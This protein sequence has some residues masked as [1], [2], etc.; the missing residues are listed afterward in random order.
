MGRD[1]ARARFPEWA[2][3]TP[4][5]AEAWCRV[6]SECCTAEEF[7]LDLTSTPG[8]PWNRSAR[9]VFIDDFLAVGVYGCRNR[10]KIGTAFDRHFRTLKKQYTRLE[11][12][13]EAEAEGT[14]VDRSME[15]QEHAREQR[16]YNRRL[17]VALYYPETRKHV[18]ILKDLGPE[19]MS[20]DEEN[21]VGGTLWKEYGVHRMPWRDKAVTHNL[22]VLDALR[23]RYRSEEGQGERRGA[24]PRIRFL[25]D[26]PSKRTRAV[27]R[28][29]RNAY[30]PQWLAGL[31]T[32]QR[33]DL[34]HRQ[35]NHDFSH[36]PEIMRFGCCT[37]TGRPR[38]MSIFTGL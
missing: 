24:R 20:S 9:K 4:E 38:L 22:R 5:V 31:N 12:D 7:C 17:R 25:T 26:I 13:A 10:E 28:L 15:E 23:R 35:D 16:R 32:L 27:P 36:D 6:D 11:E 34:Q 37:L 29:P 19:G 18:P 21:D 1:C 14:K 2:I 8:T 3:A 30:D 33:A